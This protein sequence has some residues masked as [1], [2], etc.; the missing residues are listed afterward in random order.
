MIA[1]R[2]PQVLEKAR[3]MQ[4]KK[5]SPRGSFESSKTRHRLIVKQCLSRLVSKGLDHK[6]SLLLKT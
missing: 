5:L 6:F 2:N 1:W 4:V 3:A